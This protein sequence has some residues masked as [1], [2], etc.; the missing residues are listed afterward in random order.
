MVILRIANCRMP[1]A[2][3]Q[4]LAIGNRKSAMLSF[5]PQ[6]DQRIDLRRTSRRN[7][8]SQQ[9]RDSED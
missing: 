8:T 7:V 9:C 6:R 3:F 2:D 4:K 5:I 1:I